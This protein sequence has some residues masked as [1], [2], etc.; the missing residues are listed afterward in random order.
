MAVPVHI[1]ILVGNGDDLVAISD[2]EIGKRQSRVEKL[3]EQVAAEE[4]KRIDRE[5]GLSNDIAAA[6]LDAEEARLIAQ[7]E[8]AKEANKVS[9]VKGGVSSV[10]DP[11]EEDRKN[12]LALQQAQA[13]AV[14]VKA[15]NAAEAKAAAKTEKEA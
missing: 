3:R 4:A 11:V 7:L 8:A 5:A 13:D 12:A 6:Q 9:A 15:E 2:E 14:K 10:L 1:G